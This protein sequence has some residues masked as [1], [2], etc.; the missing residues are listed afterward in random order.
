MKH[1]MDMTGLEKYSIS[2]RLQL[3]MTTIALPSET[4][5]QVYCHR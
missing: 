5:V 4:A 1:I 2:K 3:K